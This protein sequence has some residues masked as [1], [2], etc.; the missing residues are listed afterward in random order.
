M[1]APALPLLPVSP[2]LAGRFGETVTRAWTVVSVIERARA[3]GVSLRVEDRTLRLAAAAPEPGLLAL[4][5]A[6]APEI[7]AWLRP[8]A[9][10]W[11]AADW[12]RF[13]EER[14]AVGEYAGLARA[15][16]EA[17]A[18]QVCVDGWLH[19]NPIT[20]SPD[21]RRCSWC[22]GAE[23]AHDLFMPLGIAGAGQA[24]VHRGCS[25]AWAGGRRAEAGRALEAFGIDVTTVHKPHDG[26][27]PGHHARY[28][29]RSRIERLDPEQH[30]EAA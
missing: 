25:P 6:H 15:E 3:A 13:F 22:F 14:V 7:V 16:A 21:A 27:F 5:E 10:G 20:T 11:A 2:L 9:D 29:L 26:P 8:A 1:T 18:Y 24:W 30:R 17:R 12:R 4:L 28:I 19:A 23:R